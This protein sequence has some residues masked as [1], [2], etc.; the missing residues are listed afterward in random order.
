MDLRQ[1]KNK[2]VKSM[3]RKRRKEKKRRKV[4][5]HDSIYARIYKRIL[6]R[7]NASKYT[8]LHTRRQ[9]GK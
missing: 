3:Q 8:D 2:N 6:K 9:I 7:K 1:E 5:K 4:G